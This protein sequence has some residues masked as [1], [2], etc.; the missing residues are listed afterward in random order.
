MGTQEKIDIFFF[1]T[2]KIKGLLYFCPLHTHTQLLY[3][4]LYC[5]IRFKKKDYGFVLKL[6]LY[7][8][9]YKCSFIQFQNITMCSTIFY[10]QSLVSI[11]KILHKK[12]ILHFDNFFQVFLSKLVRW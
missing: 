8:R 7:S 2:L 5:F 12:Q 3:I 6:F 11:I 1:S 4:Y 9:F 10:S